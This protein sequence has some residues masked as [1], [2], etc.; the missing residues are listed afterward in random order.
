VRE[1]EDL[2]AY[3][4]AASTTDLAAQLNSDQAP[5]DVNEIE[6]EDW[7]LRFLAH[8]Q[9]YGHTIYNLDFA[10]P[11]PADD[12]TPVL[13]T[14]KMFVNG[15][16]VNPYERQ[17]AS[18]ERREQATQSMQKR[19]KGVRLNLFQSNLDRA[20]RY[21]PLRED[22]LADVGMS[23]PLLRQM[24]SEIGQRFAEAGLIEQIDDIYWLEQD[25]VEQVA[26]RLD[27]GDALSSLAEVIPQRKAIW[28]SANR[29]TPPMALPQ[30]KVFGKD[31]LKLKSGRANKDG[32]DTL[33]GVAA[34]PGTVTAPASVLKGPE[35]F[36]K[37]RTGNVLVA[38]IT[39][40]AWTP[41]FARAA[42]VVT[43]VGGPLS[44]GSIVA[45]EY[46]IP[47]VLGT[48]SATKDIQDGQTITVDGDT[49]LVTLIQDV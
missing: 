37:M 16:G 33:K 13:E 20:Q 24:L 15:Q 48:D 6:W 35:D 39:T 29:A 49:G 11:V 38:S 34:S 47:A 21:A 41:L 36:S 18:V 28:Q 30:I 27:R 23:Y 8:L 14:L 9:E 40:P 5:E 43:D 25:E 7:Y 12:P 1:S 17:K 46:G 3:L 44:H 2:S 31:I 19:L 10:N 42:A 26:T 4:K 32:E 22:G 45:R